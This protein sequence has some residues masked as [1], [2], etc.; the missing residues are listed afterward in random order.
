MYESMMTLIMINHLA[1]KNDMVQ[2]FIG[3]I[4]NWSISI[5]HVQEYSSKNK[6]DKKGIVM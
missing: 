5:H 2:D 4:I 1:I 6:H 3:Q